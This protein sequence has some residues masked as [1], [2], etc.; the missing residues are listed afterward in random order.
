MLELGKPKLSLNMGDNMRGKK[1]F[2][3]HMGKFN[4][5]LVTSGIAQRLTR[6]PILIKILLM[7]QAIGWSGLSASLSLFANGT[8]TGCV[9]IESSFEERD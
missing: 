3:R 9:D 6:G 8:A 2:Y 7:I 5:L 1:S 4:V